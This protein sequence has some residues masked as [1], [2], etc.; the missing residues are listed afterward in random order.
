MASIRDDELRT[1]SAICCFVG[2]TEVISKCARCNLDTR[3]LTLQGLLQNSPSRAVMLLEFGIDTQERDR[4]TSIQNGGNPSRRQLAP[5]SASSLRHI[6]K[7]RIVR[8][9]Q[10]SSTTHDR[11]MPTQ[12]LLNRRTKTPA[13]IGSNHCPAILPLKRQDSRKPICLSTS[14]SW[15]GAFQ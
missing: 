6:G 13:I 14:F 3:R 1:S 8:Q 9:G 11:N 7:I 5:P 15:V 2:N 10:S 12:Q 4:A